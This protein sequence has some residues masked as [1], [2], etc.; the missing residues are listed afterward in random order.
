MFRCGTRELTDTEKCLV[1]LI[2]GLTSKEGP[3]HYFDRELAAMMRLTR[4]RTQI[5]LED[6]TRRRYVIELWPGEG[7]V[8]RVAAP[9]VSSKTLKEIPKIE[10]NGAA[11]PQPDSELLPAKRI[12]RNCGAAKRLDDFVK[13][14][15]APQGRTNECRLCHNMRNRGR[16]GHSKA[17]R[18]RHPDRVKARNAFPDV[19]AASARNRKRR[20]AATVRTAGARYMRWHGKINSFSPVTD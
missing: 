18:E 6:L 3:C 7:L 16:N 13:D 2:D 20:Q 19:R 14:K 1:A 4:V 5:M 17:W 12:C 11:L 15:S 9:E 8:C 10:T